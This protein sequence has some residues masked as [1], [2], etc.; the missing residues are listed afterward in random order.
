VSDGRRS[1][2]GVVIPLHAA[3]SATPV[4]SGP[5]R[6]RAAAHP[7]RR[8]RLLPVY[9]AV[10]GPLQKGATQ[11]QCL[12]GQLQPPVKEGLCYRQERQ[13]WQQVFVS[14]SD[15][16]VVVLIAKQGL[17]PGIDDIMQVV[18]ER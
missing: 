5:P 4:V 10:S 7:R 12:E 14:C 17:E 3:G 15:S 6:K 11:K 1:G 16:S 13:G 9:P 2:T 18:T 8:C